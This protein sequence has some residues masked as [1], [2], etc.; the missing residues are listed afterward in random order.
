MFNVLAAAV[1]LSLVSLS[2]AAPFKYLSLAEIT[3]QLHALAKKHPEHLRV[4][5]AQE[6]F[7]VPYASGTCKNHLRNGTLAEGRCTVWVAELGKRSNEKMEERPEMLVSG[8]VHGDEVIGPQ[9]TIAFLHFMLANYKRDAYIRQ[10]VDSRLVTIVPTG[11]ALGYEHGK[12]GEF[13]NRTGEKQ[14]MLDPNRDFAFDTHPRGCMR[15]VVARVFNELMRRRLFRVLVTFH[16]GTNVIGYEWGD[17][18]HCKGRECQ[19]SPDIRLMRALAK[20]MADNAG[21]AGM[22]EPKYPIGTMGK[23]V[24]PVHGGMEDW[25]YGASWAGQGVKCTPRTYGGYPLEKTEYFPDMTRCVT[26]LV[27]TGMSKRPPEKTLGDSKRML[28]RGGKGDG[29]V[30]RN[31]RLL[32]TAV[33][34]LEPYVVLPEGPRIDFNPEDRRVKFSWKIGGAFVVDGTYLQWGTNAGVHGTTKVQSG[35][36]GG[37]KFVGNSTTFEDVIEFNTRRIPVSDVL[38]VRV[39]AVVDNSLDEVVKGNVPNMAPQSHLQH[40]RS[41]VDT[42]RRIGRRFIKCRRVVYSKTVRVELQETHLR[43]IADGK[44]KW[45][46]GA[47]KIR[48]PSDT[49]TLHQL[50]P[51]AWTLKSLSVETWGLIIAGTLFVLLPT[52]GFFLCC[53]CRRESED[54][55]DPEVQKELLREDLLDEDD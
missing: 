12:R 25:A 33:D 16:G 5:S 45:G 21:P 31:V 10:M 41:H 46:L 15:T 22:F 26:F 14:I 30:P 17:K 32:L 19:P 40:A 13:Y 2:S 4:Y 27:E 24:Y 50:Y 8:A 1:V 43:V 51:Q 34:A 53:C 52:L 11:N 9:A 44:V 35:W 3:L 18:T 42:S 29:H 49:A 6:E 37:R 23:L 54:T 55:E 39:A 38:Y 48:A 28:L 47:G 20:R 36:A 7:G